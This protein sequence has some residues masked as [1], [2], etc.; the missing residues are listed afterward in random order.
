MALEGWFPFELYDHCQKGSAIVAIIWKLL[1]SK[2]DLS[3]IS[4]DIDIIVVE[5]RSTREIEMILN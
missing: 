1:C 2:T 3:S 4:N 5:P